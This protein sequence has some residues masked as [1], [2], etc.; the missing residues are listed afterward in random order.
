MTIS[1]CKGL[2]IL[3]LILYSAINLLTLTRFPFVHS[4]EAWLAGLSQAYLDAG[5]PFVTEPFFDLMPRQA[6]MIKSL[7]H[8]LQS[9]FIA[10]FGFNIFAVR[11]LS[12]VAG[13]LVLLLMHSV[14]QR[15]LKSDVLAFLGMVLFSINLQFIYASH[16]A[17]QEILLSLVLLLCIETLTR[18]RFT[19]TGTTIDQKTVFWLGSL[20][21]LSIGFHPNA[22]IIAVMV[23]A[24]LVYKVIQG[25]LSVK[26]LAYYGLTLAGFALLY[27]AL[28]LV[29]NPNFFSDYWAFGQTLSVD[30]APVNRLTNYQHFFVKL[31]DHISGTYY[32]PDIRIILLVSLMT[33][34]S[35]VVY[36]ITLWHQKKAHRHALGLWLMMILGFNAA[37]FA[38]GRYN[39]TSI[40]FLLYPIYLLFFQLIADLKRFERPLLY[41]LLTAIALTSLQTGS[42]LNAHRADTYTTYLTE[43]EM[44]LPVNAVVLGNLNSGFAFKDV[45]F[46][47]IRNLYYLDERTLQDY[48]TSKGIN[49]IIYY[50]AYDYIHRNP[51]WQILYGDDS[52]YYEA[53]NALIKKNGTLLHHFESPVYGNR[54]VKYIG[55]YPWDVSIYT[56]D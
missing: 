16:F 47:D 17:R 51:E 9:L 46:Y 49:T 41:I 31:Y 10:T 7:F 54:I 4:D 55:D 19:T 40:I 5:S 3:Y 23:G 36:W 28:S 37:V 42:A 14:L 21:G 24:A 44:H 35:G 20:I 38:I 39:P 32:L 8:G 56:I 48:I 12:L 25:T 45:P 18:E 52:G 33:T 43:I 30:A 50:E 34:I 29:G 6:H 27:V 2:T 53:L 11:L 22:F 1:K 13:I 15:I 26:S